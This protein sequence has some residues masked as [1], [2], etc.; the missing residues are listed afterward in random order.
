MSD[1]LLQSDSIPSLCPS[2]TLRRNIAAK[3]IPSS[4]TF[5]P[6][7]CIQIRIGN[8]DWTKQTTYPHPK[9]TNILGTTL[10]HLTSPSPTSAMHPKISTLQTPHL[11]TQL[12]FVES[13]GVLPVRCQVVSTNTAWLQKKGGYTLTGVHLLHCL[14]YFILFCWIRVLVGWSS[15]R[16]LISRAPSGLFKWGNLKLKET[17]PGPG[18]FCPFHYASVNLG[19]GCPTDCPSAFS[20]SSGRCPPR[21]SRHGR[22]SG[23]TRVVYTEIFLLG[24]DI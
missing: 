1:T 16:L 4:K 14:F 18:S 23:Q 17:E 3:G 10:F 9:T 13:D 5:S 22:D 7:Q 20:F 6:C 12:A 15:S 2:G 8:W 19:L 21:P 24:V 11:P